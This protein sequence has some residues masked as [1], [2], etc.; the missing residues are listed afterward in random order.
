[1]LK[2]DTH[3]HTCFSKDSEMSLAFAYYTGVPALEVYERITKIIRRGKYI[4]ELKF[5][6]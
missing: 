5:N 1:M 3:I 6:Q 2:V 4:H